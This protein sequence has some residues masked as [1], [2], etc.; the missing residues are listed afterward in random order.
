MRLHNTANVRIDD[1]NMRRKLSGV[2]VT[3]YDWF[4]FIVRLIFFSD[5]D[6]K[7]KDSDGCNDDDSTIRTYFTHCSLFHYS[8]FFL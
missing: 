8:H 6:C 1:K 7:V 3:K 2:S 5:D 4:K